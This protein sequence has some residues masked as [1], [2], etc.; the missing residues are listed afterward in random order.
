MLT[1]DYIF[2]LSLTGDIVG[3]VLRRLDSLG[4]GSTKDDDMNW[5]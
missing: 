1:L 5:I 4:G 2:S 3:N